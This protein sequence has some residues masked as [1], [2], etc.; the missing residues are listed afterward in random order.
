MR[1]LVADDERNIRESL[2]SFLELEGNEVVTA[3][4]GLAAQRRLQEEA[5]GAAIVDLKMPGMD[6]LELLRWIRSERSRLPV[7]MISAYG[8]VTDAVTA[9]KLGAQD[10]VVKPFDPEELVLRLG[11][12]VEVQAL[13]DHAEVASRDTAE[14]PA[15]LGESPP[16]GRYRRAGAQGSP[17]P[18]HRADHRRER[19]REGSGGR[20]RCTAIRDARDRSFRSTAAAFPIPCWRVSCSA[21]NAVRSRAPRSAR[22]ACSSW[23]PQAPCF[24]MKSARCR[25][26]CR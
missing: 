25:A 3:E 13:R 21:T 15:E 24:S 4:N 26:S 19:H 10:Y 7:I 17:H 2:R 8:E 23:L 9:M 16:M 18:R 11:K 6:G 20:V 1:V 22:S 12:L 14:S 5:F